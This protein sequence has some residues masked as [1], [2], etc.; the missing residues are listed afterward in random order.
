M[1]IESLTSN[2]FFGQVYVYFV[3]F[4]QH[5]KWTLVLDPLVCYLF[6]DVAINFYRNVLF[7]LNPESSIQE[8]L[9]IVS[10]KCVHN[11]VYP[12]NALLSMVIF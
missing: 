5:L 6:V 10:T 1:D 7:F 8:V 9:I 3:T 12:A 2:E 11:F 4:E